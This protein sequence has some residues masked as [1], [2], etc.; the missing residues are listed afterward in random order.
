MTAKRKSLLLIGILCLALC[1]CFSACRDSEVTETTTQPDD[2]TAQMTYSIAVQSEGGVA[3]EGLSVFIYADSNLTDMVAVDKTD[4]EGKMSF[5]Y[6][7]SDSYVAVLTNVPEGYVVEE[8]YEIKEEVTTI[9][10]ETQLVESDLSTAVY[11]LGGVMGDF[12]F[13]AADGAE[14][15]LS[16]LL[17]HKKAV[18]LNFWFMACNPCKQEFPYLQEA[19]EEYSDDV[20]VLAMNPIDTD[21]AEV[22]A[23]AEKLGITFPIGV[24]DSNWANAMRL[25]SYPTTVVID[26]FGTVALLHVGSIP[27]AQ[28]FKDV[29]AFFTADDY[30]QTVVNSVEDLETTEKPADAVENP[31]DVGGTLTFDL[32]LEPGQIHYVNIYKVTNVWLQVD[33][34]DIYVEYGDKTY[35]ASGGSVGLLISAPSTYEPAYVGFGNSGDTTHAFTVNMSPLA[36]SID[37]PYKFTLGEF[38]AKVAANNEVGI[39]YSYTVPEDGYLTLECLSVSPSNVDYDFFIQN[40]NT[41]AFRN[42]GSDGGNNSESGNPS[43]TVAVNKGDGLR[44]SIGTLPDDT[45]IYPAGTFKML[46][47][48]TA[49]EVEDV[50][51]LG[52]IDYAVTV[53]DENRDP[54]AGVKVNL[55]GTLGGKTTMVTDENGVA[56]MKLTE[57]V[58]TGSLVLPVGYT[59]NTTQFEVTPESPFAS[60]KLDTVQ[61]QEKADYVVRVI[62]ASGNPVPGTI[63][64]IGTSFGITDEDGVYTVNLPVDSYTAVIGAPAGYVAEAV[65]VPFPEGSQTLAITLQKAG[66][67][68]GTTDPQPTQP[69]VTQPGETQP[70]DTTPQ[71]TIPGM[72]IPGATQPGA[73]TPQATVPGATIPGATIPGATLPEETEDETTAPVVTTPTTA[74]YTV[75]VTDHTGMPVTNIMVAFLKN[76]VPVSITTVNNKGVATVVLDKDQYTVSLTSSSGAALTYDAASA[77]LSV[78]KPSVTVK[79]ATATNTSTYNNEAY[80]G[81]FYTLSSGSTI[82]DFTNNNNYQAEEGYWMF[83]YY[84]SMSGEY[85]VT[86]GENVEAAYFGSI[87]F[88]NKSKDS[89]NADRSFTV[90]SKDGEFANN[91]Q[92]SYVFGFKPQNGATSAVITVVRTGDAPAEL[93]VNIY[94]SAKTPTTFTMKESGTLTYVDITKDVTIKKKADGNYY[95]TVGGKDKKLY[96]NLAMEAPYLTMSNMMGLSYS[97]SEW[98]TGSMGTGLKGLLYEGD[99][100]VA[101]EDFTTCMHTYIKATDINTGLYPLNDD[102][103]YMFQQAGSYMRWWVKDHPNYLFGDV[104]VDPDSAWMFAVCYM[105]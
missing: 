32:T 72:T 36:G 59:V 93:P 10:L 2:V 97:G 63:I 41:N 8:A 70:G 78:N 7:P 60:L 62:D 58:Y 99:V 98:A 18:V 22:P 44:I 55:S 67:N 5:T 37:N 40:L 30:V 29:F 88:L 27:N 77:V 49:G 20:M 12:T 74:A 80:W 24:C 28:V 102:L 25:M 19:Y 15:K 4:A 39:Y 69:Q 34:S 105:S 91:N 90:T 38:T 14:Y 33:N 76:G 64:A 47:S 23:F 6:T 71:I 81:G 66:G 16:E 96:V 73:T 54:V 3:L 65:S 17:E 46:A 100:A 89:N 31:V 52:K 35:T 85:T 101:I 51:V 103:K 53:T 9:I 56:S 84:P 87:N 86:A 13:T 68:S 79:V 50:V 21:N 48:F 45:H 57:D 1:L 104:T 43:L 75:K 94:E 83:V 11:K 82:I 95:I 42:L 26:R 61:V 92:P